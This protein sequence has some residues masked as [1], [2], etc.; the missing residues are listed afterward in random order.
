V[1]HESAILVAS[2]DAMAEQVR[3]R[4]LQRVLLVPAAVE[5]LAQLGAMG[6]RLLEVERHAGLVVAVAQPLRP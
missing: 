6:R 3:R 2:Q 4:M 5:E 1:P